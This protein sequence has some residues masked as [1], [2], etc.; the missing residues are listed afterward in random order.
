MNF[1][2]EK[3]PLLGLFLFCFLSATIVPISSEAAL[4]AY[5]SQTDAV[6]LAF[7]AASAGNVSGIILNYWLGYG[8]DRWSE[9]RFVKI[10]ESMKKVHAYS[11][12]YG[13]WALLFSGLPF[14][15]DPIT[16]L[17]GYVKINFW[18]FLL[19]AGLIRIA[20]Y[21]VILQFFVP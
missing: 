21:F 3:L 2:A 17:A 14:I 9:H 20:R 11:E 15:G 19:I 1:L 8:L 16:I 18:I 13:K 6:W 4:A 12:K 7:I 10:R 5:M